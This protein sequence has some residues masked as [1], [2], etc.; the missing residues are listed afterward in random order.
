[1]V[2]A[3]KHAAKSTPDELKSWKSIADFLGQPISTVQRWAKTGMPVNRDGRFVTAS[4]EQLSHWLGET[5]GTNGHVHIAEGNEKDL[6][7]ELLEGLSLVRREHRPAARAR[8]K[9]QL[10]T[11]PRSRKISG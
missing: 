1:M 11:M 10:K 8:P 6:T 3:K 5:T 9:R 2:Q 7:T 4:R